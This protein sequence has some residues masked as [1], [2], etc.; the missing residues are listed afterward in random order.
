[1]LQFVE[2]ALDEVALA[3]EGEV[4]RPRLLAVGLRRDDRRDSPLLERLDERVGVVALVGDDG[5]G[6]KRFEQ[7]LG[8]RDI[9]S[10]ARCERKCD[11]VAERVD[12][13]VD[14]RRQA[15]ARAADG[16][17]LAVFFWAPALC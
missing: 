7:R 17:A 13:G 8:L 12:D 10:L 9:G 14:L 16:L 11:G 15:A 1:V 6:L 4:R 5:V 3:V 2:E